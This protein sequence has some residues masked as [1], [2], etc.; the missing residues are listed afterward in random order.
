MIAIG[1]EPD[2]KNINDGCG[3]VHLDRLRETVARERCQV[4]IALDGDGDRAILIDENGAIFD[5]D[6]VMAVMGRR[7]ARDGRLSTTPSSPP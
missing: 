7:M 5:G 1:V 4:G 3:A 6:D 2:G